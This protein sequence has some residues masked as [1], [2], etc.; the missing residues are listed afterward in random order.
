MF[1][2]VFNWQKIVVFNYNTDYKIELSGTKKAGGFI[3]INWNKFDKTVELTKN[4]Y[5][6]FFQYPFVKYLIDR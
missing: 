2:G 5:N 4:E 6:L 3:R 1:V